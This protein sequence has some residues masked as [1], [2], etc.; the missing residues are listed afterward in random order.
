[1]KRS[2]SSTARA[3]PGKS[4]NG[5]TSATAR[6]ESAAAFDCANSEIRCH[7]PV[8]V[9]TQE[10]TA[11]KININS[12]IINFVCRHFILLSWLRSKK[13]K[14][15]NDL[16]VW[17]NSCNLSKCQKEAS[18]QNKVARQRAEEGQPNRKRNEMAAV[19]GCEPH[20]V[21]KQ[22]KRSAID[23]PPVQIELQQFA[24]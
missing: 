12:S 1:M 7:V 13:K 8:C 14:E 17:D 22:R 21:Q 18:R 23:S 3:R 11:S 5:Q 10:V 9:A 24:G 19:C 2:P 6:I 16:P 15:E 4:N 20:G